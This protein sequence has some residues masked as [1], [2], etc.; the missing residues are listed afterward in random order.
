MPSTRWVGST[1][2]AGTSRPRWSPTTGRGADRG[3]RAVR[4]PHRRGPVRRAGPAPRPRGGARAHRA[5]PW[6][7][8]GSAPSCSST[9]SWPSSPASRSPPSWPRSTPATCRWS[10]TS[11]GTCWSSP[12][13]T[14]APCS[15][16]LRSVSST[17][18]VERWRGARGRGRR[19]ALRVGCP[20]RARGGDVAR[21]RRGRRGRRDPGARRHRRCPGSAGSAP[22]LQAELEHRRDAE[23][24]AKGEFEDVLAAIALRRAARGAGTRCRGSPRGTGSSV[25]GSPCSRG[26]YARGRPELLAERTG[27]DTLYPALGAVLA[28]EPRAGAGDARGA[29]SFASDADGPVTAIEVELEPHLVASHAYRAAGRS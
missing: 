14:S 5:T 21:R 29:Q 2:L 17:T 23:A 27:E 28:G 4:R 3:R 10:A 22:A 12:R 8:C 15:A 9:S 1:P 16:A 7:R 19:D 13:S 26:D 11:T 18:C 25:A 20:N 24:L 6:R